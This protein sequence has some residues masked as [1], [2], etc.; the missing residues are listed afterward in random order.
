MNCD[1]AREWFPALLDG[2]IGL[3]EAVLVE[4]HVSQCAE[5]HEALDLLEGPKAAPRAARLD[6]PP[7]PISEVP[8]ATLPLEASP[9]LRHRLLPFTVFRMS[10]IAV[11][12]MLVAAFGIHLAF[13]SPEPD[14]E[15]P[16]AAAPPTLGAEPTPAEPTPSQAAPTPTTPS[17]PNASP[18]TPV[19]VRPKDPKPA[20]LALPP[21]AERPAVTAKIGNPKADRPAAAAQAQ[22]L[23]APDKAVTAK[24]NG[25]KVAQALPAPDKAAAAKPNGEK[26]AQAR[27]APDKAAAAKPNGEKAPPSPSAAP[28]PSPDR[29]PAAEQASPATDSTADVVM[30]LAARDR[31][32]AMRDLR[33]LLARLG[34]TAQGR[35]Q[36]ATILVVV[37]HSRYSDFTRSLTRIGTWQLEAER[38]SLPDPVRVTV[39]MVR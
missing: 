27:P 6:A 18:V 2:E 37:P 4:A 31:S 9:P 22:A 35:D 34:G 36:G 10:A 1:E 19:E 16:H 30:Q 13:R 14:G 38:S 28:A 39:R 8:D 17:A 15:V 25:E 20:P 26:V 5:C 12:L 11:A 3:T 23:P 24:P 21:R 7:V 32:T 33:S 29:G